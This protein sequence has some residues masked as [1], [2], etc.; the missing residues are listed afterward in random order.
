[1]KSVRRTWW[2][3]DAGAGASAAACT[4]S[5]IRASTGIYKQFQ[6]MG[7]NLMGSI[8][9]DNDNISPCSA[10]LHPMV[11]MMMIM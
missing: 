5:S 6:W 10:V 2:S 1:M 9:Y 8:K 3:E 7:A 11:D 4:H